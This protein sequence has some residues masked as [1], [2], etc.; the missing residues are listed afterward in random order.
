MNE[1]LH[2]EDCE[3]PCYLGI[4]PGKTSLAEAKVILEKTGARYIGMHPSDQLNFKQYT[5]RMRIGL[6]DYAN[7]FQG[8]NLYWN[9]TYHGITLFSAS[10]V[11]EGIDIYVATTYESTTE[12]KETFRKYWSQYSAREIL[13]RYGVPSQIALEKYYPQMPF[14]GRRLL[15]V[16]QNQEVVI[17]IYGNEE[18]N[19]ICSKPGYETRSLGINMVVIDQTSGI[20]LNA[21]GLSPMVRWQWIPIEEALG[22]TNEEFYNRITANPSACFL[23]NSGY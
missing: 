10:D 2:S 21:G 18:E 6:P 8:E 9:T 20:D 15:L 13:R 4:I 16:Y 17:E 23:P 1:L 19:N 14:L 5:Y 22:I 11:V 7:Q 3:L 12:Q